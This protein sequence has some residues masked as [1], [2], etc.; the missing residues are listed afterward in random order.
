M[1]NV[2]FQ[3]PVP[4]MSVRA[5]H[6][7]IKLM[8]ALQFTAD[9]ERPLQTDSDC[10]LS[11]ILWPPQ[12][13]SSHRCIWIKDMD[14]QIMIDYNQITTQTSYPTYCMNPTGV[15]TMSGILCMHV[16][17]CDLNSCHVVVNQ[18]NKRCND[19]SCDLHPKIKVTLRMS[20]ADVQTRD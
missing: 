15:T 4:L 12:F 2:Y 20:W 5:L 10:W 18:Y 1:H 7:Q 6:G 14:N 17:R 8:V 19:K 9:F 11:L 3:R 16:R 13:T